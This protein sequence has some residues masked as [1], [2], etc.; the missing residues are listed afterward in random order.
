VPLLR[1]FTRKFFITY[2]RKCAL[3]WIPDAF[4]VLILILK[5]WFAVYTQ[6]A[7]RLCDRFS[8]FLSLSSPN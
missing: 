3:W 6:D 2:S 5:L 1:K 8:S 4:N 7:A